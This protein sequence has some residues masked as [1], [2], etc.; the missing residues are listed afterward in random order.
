[1][2]THIAIW[3]RH[4]I[5]M[6]VPALVLAL[7]L[8]MSQAQET[9]DPLVLTLDRSG[10]ILFKTE[11]GLNYQLI[12]SSDLRQW[13]PSGNV[14]EG[15]G[16]DQ[17]IKV[18]LGDE[19]QEFFQ[20]QTSK[21]PPKSAGE[22]FNRGMDVWSLSVESPEALL[23]QGLEAVV[24]ASLLATGGEELIIYGTLQ[25]DG[26]QWAWRPEPA[27]RLRV[28]REA[29]IIELRFE[30]LQG[31]F[32]QETVAGF[33]AGS[34]HV[35]VTIEDPV[36]NRMAL[37]IISR[38]VGNREEFSS[39]GMIRDDAGNEYEVAYV[40]EGIRTVDVEVD[41]AEYDAERSSLITAK[42]P[43]FDLRLGWQETYKSIYFQN[44]VENRTR[45]YEGY[46]TI[47]NDTWLLS[48]VRIRTALRNTHV[49][50]FDSYWIVQ[51]SI[52]HNGVP[53]AHLSI[54]PFGQ[55]M[56]IMVDYEN[57]SLVLERYTTG[58]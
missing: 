51:G 4:G 15:T 2:I 36:N 47:G 21:S 10:S 41:S 28:Q 40:S 58:N 23:E 45:N 19:N 54:R 42:A 29:E 39:T 25:L 11:V 6:L 30:T 32:Q 50:D 7:Q 44:F 46:W 13:S 37:R 49:T 16:T 31:D 43:G 9:S 1:M 14:I 20:I 26:Q 35:A 27:D 12:V 55:W 52:L 34:H 22:L 17:F 18:G 8:L 38:L 24:T 57:E 33:L 53:F 48:H 3:I 56:Q 5:S